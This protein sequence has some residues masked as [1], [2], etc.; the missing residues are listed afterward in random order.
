MHQP[1]MDDSELCS[2]IAIADRDAPI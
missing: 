1:I 2:D